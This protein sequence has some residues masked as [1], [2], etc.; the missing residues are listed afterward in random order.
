[1]KM[2]WLS[3]LL[4]LGLVSAC[5]QQNDKTT[6]QP[7]TQS[8]EPVKDVNLK[9]SLWGDDA[10]KKLFD[11]LM[12]KYK[13]THPNV[14]VE[15]ILIPSAEYQ[16]KLSI[17]F[18]SKTGPDLLW[19]SERMVPQFIDSKQLM[20]VSS[21]QSDASYD[22]NDIYGATLD[23]YKRSQQLYGITFTAGPKVLY[24]NKTMFKE[25]GLKEPLDLYK[26][27]K[28]TYDEMIK[29]A[30]ALADPAKGTYGI[31]LFAVSGWKNW[32]DAMMDTF[33]AYGADL[34][35]DKGDKLLL[36]SAEG[37]KSLQLLSDLIFKDQSHVKPGDQTT[38]ESG[39]IGMARANYSYVTNAR[40]ITGF[41]WEIA[42]M[43][44]GPKADAPSAVGIAGY[45]VSQDSKYPK[46]SLELLKYLT[47]KQG[48]SDLFTTFAPVR[49]SLLESDAF[50]KAAPKPSEDA[51]RQ[52]YVNILNS[53]KVRFQPSHPNWQQIDVK[54]QTLMD[55]LFT[56]SQ[57]PKQVLDQMDK[58]VGPLL[59]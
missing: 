44:K 57:T 40:K 6:S 53:G 59:K 55:S 2:W 9:L 46:E 50:L 30:K 16:Q 18:A 48:M 3:C 27:G 28:W 26:E 37:E 1:M 35:N 21:I 5:S 32:Q 22:Y 20:D 36:N 56:Q 14:N 34:F 58:E 29:T 33:W 4:V 43:P 25:K 7:K 8:Q 11:E 19:L 51:I 31:N 13:E 52:S 47:S 41:E 42:P 39:K 23:I 17:M 45:S 38:F 15:I 24:Y 12:K 10:R 54:V 49:K